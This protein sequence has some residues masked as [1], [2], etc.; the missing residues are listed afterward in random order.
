MQMIRTTLGH[1]NTRR[2]SNCRRISYFHTL[3][4]Y[5]QNKRMRADSSYITRAHVTYVG[6][7]VNVN[8]HGPINHQSHSIDLTDQTV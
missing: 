3:K 8:Y 1:R 7:E 5:P 4:N 6:K 2:T